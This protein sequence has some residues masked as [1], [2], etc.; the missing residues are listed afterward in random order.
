MSHAESHLI[1]RAGWLRAAILGANDGIIS[2]SS[3]VLGVASAGASSSSILL[4]GIA[5]MVAG[6]LSMAAGEYVSVSGQADL[7]Q[8]DLERERKELET[9]PEGEL[10]ELAQIYRD[11]GLGDNL[12][13]QVAAELMEKDALGAHAREELGITE[14]VAA[15]PMQAALS[16]ALAFVTGAI[17]PVVLA[18]LAPT[19][20]AIPVIGI[21][22]LIALFLLGIV[23]AVAGG[24]DPWRPAIRVV[25]WGAVAMAVTALIGKLVGAAL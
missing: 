25:F 4:T 20:Y 11:R 23:G 7:E 10:E 6:A 2:T 9:N 19:A 1:H 22:C 14:V 15:Q 5:G 8:A 3:L 12:A 18:A 21:G 13:R 24:A 17:A 16:S